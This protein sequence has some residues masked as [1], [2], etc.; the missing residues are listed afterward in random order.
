MPPFPELERR[1]RRLLFRA[2]HRGT[3]ESDLLI[4]GFVAAR[5]ETLTAEDITALEALLE[6]SDPVLADW[7]VGRADIPPEAE[8]P[9][10]RE[11]RAAAGV[12]GDEP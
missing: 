9:M 12:A 4:G 1:R 2:T 7:L 10:L 8:T 6:T 5:L 11:M 3:H